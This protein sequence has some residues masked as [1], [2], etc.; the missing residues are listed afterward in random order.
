MPHLIDVTPGR[1]FAYLDTQVRI[2]LGLGDGLV[3]VEVIETGREEII[4]I[5]MLKCLS[6]PD[7]ESFN[8]SISSW[9]D[10]DVSRKNKDIAVV[11][12]NA[13]TKALNEDAHRGGLVARLQIELDLSRRSVY[14]LL[15]NYSEARG[16]LSVL[17]EKRGRA[18]G[19]RLLDSKVETI[20]KNCSIVL[21]NKK[22]RFTYANVFRQ[23]DKHCKQQGLSTPNLRTVKLRVKEY[24]TLKQ[25]AKLQK[26]AKRAA[27]ETRPKP[28]S[29][30]LTAPLQLVQIDHTPVDIILVDE[31]DRKP[32]GRPWVTFAIDV[33]SRII[34]GV[35]LSWKHP[36]RYTV[37]CCM[38]N[39]CLPKDSWLKDIGCEGLNYP[40]YGM[41]LE[42]LSDHASEFKTTALVDACYAHGMKMSW[43][44]EKH[45]G[46]HIESYIG[47]VMGQVHF[48][49]GTTFSNTVDKG[50][51]NS[52]SLS[53]YTFSEFREWLLAEIERYHISP[54][55]GLGSATPKSI[56]DQNYICED[57][58]RFAPPLI[59]DPKS[60]KLDF[61]PRKE[62][63]VL[64]RGVVLE[65]INYWDS[66]LR[67]VIGEKFTCVYNPESLRF[68]W[69]KI[70]GRYRE[71]P[72]ANIMRPDVSL[73][74]L[75]RAQ[76][77]IKEKGGDP[78]DEQRL[79]ELMER[80]E[81]LDNSVKNKT[82]IA[83]KNKSRKINVEQHYFE[84]TSGEAEKKI[85]DVSHAQAVRNK[86][87]KKVFFDV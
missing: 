66:S 45:Y 49:S 65:Y 9:V 48:L 5:G 79:F 42:I 24:A 27:D 57:G 38:A 86:P 8:N 51:Y 76:R 2:I 84:T 64:S 78:R 18:T 44:K 87:P 21:L 35:Y 58:S 17:G 73:D 13:I 14:R 31:E 36:S 82:K 55:K 30:E 16:P 39:M 10:G 12:Y 11:R 6:T 47:K 50:D 61:M 41:P 63:S 7:V 15:E 23:V 81:A 60:F 77:S 46:G 69:L 3:Q 40:F 72:Y 74:Q 43:R 33:F 54:H 19:V 71:I 62:V 34:L 59:A 83:R 67:G 68:V 1:I 25:M 80:Q 37:A 32:I 26:G 29:V 22:E 4:S 56:W 75:K 53:C 85:V 20:I 52:E 70:N 28:G